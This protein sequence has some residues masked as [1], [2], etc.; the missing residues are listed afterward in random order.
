MTGGDILIRN[1]ETFHNYR[2]YSADSAITF[3]DVQVPPDVPEAKT[4]GNR[5]P[6]VAEAAGQD[7]R[8]NPQ[9]E[10]INA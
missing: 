2:K 1:D 9:E 8:Y 6:G 4:S 10:A 3:D 7:R 5:R